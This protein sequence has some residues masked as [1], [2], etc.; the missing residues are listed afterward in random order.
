MI[1][2][3][4]E[5]AGRL[6]EWFEKAKREMPWRTDPSAYHVYVSEIMLQQ[7]R[8]DTV[9]PYYRRF[10]AELP[11]IPALSSCEEERLLKLWEGLGYYSRVRNMKKT[12]EILVRDYGG[13]FPETFSE[14]RKL[15][16][17]GDYT[18]GAILSIAFRRPEPVVDGNVLRVLTRLTG[19]SE[20][21]DLERTKKH[22]RD[23][24]R[25]FLSEKST[26][27]SVFNQA[28][29]ELGALVCVPNGA[30]FCEKCPLR[31]SCAALSEGRIS[32]LPV[33]TPKT[34]RKKTEI[35]AFL[36]FREGKLLLGKNSEN[37]LLSGLWEL[38]HYE[39]GPEPEKTEAFLKKLGIHPESVR[40]L[41]DRKHVFTHIEWQLHGIEVLAAPGPWSE[42]GEEDF[43][44]MRFFGP[45]ELE[46]RI[47]LP[48]AYRK[49]PVR[50]GEN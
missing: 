28:L 22:F 16:G 6:T 41:P 29:M 37:K 4:R 25:E 11:D 39:G 31:D 13:E 48:E 24:L 1:R 30:P 21:I 26:D 23:T 34:A 12:A 14:L 19:F 15:P 10:I 42:P 43:R 50:P 32:E 18:A 33:R 46:G 27:P 49:W 35:T 20:S 3:I 47:A 38:P 17:I 5:C 8:V 36:I 9:R 45:E 2:K 7:T 40:R 44:T